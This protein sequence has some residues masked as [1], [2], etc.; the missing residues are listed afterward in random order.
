LTESLGLFVIFFLLIVYLYHFG[1]KPGQ[2]MCLYLIFSGLLRFAVDLHR[3]DFRGPPLWGLAPTS[4]T[5]LLV[6]GSGIV[7]GARLRRKKAPSKVEATAKR[8]NT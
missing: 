4:W 5:A 1:R 8:D 6:L 7:Y 3:G 2:A